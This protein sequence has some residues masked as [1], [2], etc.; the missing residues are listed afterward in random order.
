MEYRNLTEEEYNDL[1]EKN[2]YKY[3]EDRKNNYPSAEELMDAWDKKEETGDSSDWDSLLEK[4]RQI[5]EKYSKE[6]P[7]ADQLEEYG[8]IMTK[9]PEE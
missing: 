5:K 9:D 2:K 8:P 6:Y 4:R 7:P 1:V 3:R